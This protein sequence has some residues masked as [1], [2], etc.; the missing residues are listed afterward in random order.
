MRLT[1]HKTI[2]G[3]LTQG[4]IFQGHIHDTLHASVTVILWFCIAKPRY[5]YSEDY[6]SF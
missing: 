4:Q 5:V 1:F 6:M 2:C 3:S